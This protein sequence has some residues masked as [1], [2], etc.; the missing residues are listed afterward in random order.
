MLAALLD[1]PHP[2]LSTWCEALSKTQAELLKV[3]GGDSGERVAVEALKAARTYIPIASHYW[4]VR[5][6]EDGELIVK[7]KERAV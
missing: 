7:W 2:G 1:D 6:K 3:L 5:G 4:K